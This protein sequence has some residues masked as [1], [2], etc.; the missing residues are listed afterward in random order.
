MD[1]IMIDD[2]WLGLALLEKMLGEAAAGLG[3]P[4]RLH[5]FE[6][7]EEAIE[8]AGKLRP[9]AVFLDIQMPGLSGMKAAEK[10]KELCP[11][12]C[13]VFVTAYAEYAVK[14]FE[15]NAVDYLM[16]P[17]TKDRVT[18]ALRRVLDRKPSGERLQAAAAGNGG[19]RVL[20]FRSIRFQAPGGTAITP[21]WRTAKAQELFAY[22][23]QRRGAAVHKSA[24][25]EM[26]APQQE[27]KQA[28]SLL[29]TIVYQIRKTLQ[30]EGIDIEIES[31][32]VQETYS[33]RMGEGVSVDTETWEREL[34]EA[35]RGDIIRYD[36]LMK[37]LNEY[38]G[39]Y[40]AEHGYAWAEG[41]RERLRRVWL[42]HARKAAGRLAEDG[43]EEEAAKL[44]GTMQAFDP[45]DEGTALTLL[46]LYD[47]QGLYDKVVEHFGSF[48]QVFLEGLE[49]PVPVAVS[50]WYAA[51]RAG[52]IRE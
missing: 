4:V 27:K 41:E 45:Y 49:L 37:L 36:R 18:T 11:D 24:I 28:M 44:Y 8:Q 3:L 32:G 19:A 2:E 14:A 13:F 51:W 38:E 46:M 50:E 30:Q 17:Y 48:E 23:L 25:L 22:L 40:L 35:A 47:R 21:K 9:A 1:V 43:R 33:M 6:S 5:G 34:T 15:L 10:L 31:S 39:D 29:Y 52:V 42:A 7:P 26:I 12:T 16:K 20:C